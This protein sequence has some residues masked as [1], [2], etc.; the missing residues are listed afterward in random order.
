EP[1]SGAGSAGEADVETRP[2]LDDY[3]LIT[4]V[5]LSYMSLEVLLGELLGRIRT[6]L[7]A[8]TAAILL[9]DPERNVLLARA[10]RGIEEE[11]RQGVQI[12]VGRGFAGRIAYERR[13]IVIED[14]DHSYV[15]NPLLRQRGIR[16]LLGVPLLVGGRVTGVLHVGTLQPRAFAEEDV[17]LLQLA[18]DR[19]AMA[20]E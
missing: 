3:E 1:E 11:V 17:R 7:R 14:V 2:A 10:A 19:A 5:S 20:I 15:L 13:P 8:D 6:I 16:S 12:P 9:L 18:A 4:D